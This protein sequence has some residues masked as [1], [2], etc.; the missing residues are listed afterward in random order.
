MG[1]GLGEDLDGETRRRL[2][3]DLEDDGSGKGML[4]GTGA[5]PALGGEG[6]KGALKG[7]EGQKTVDPVAPV[8]KRRGAEVEKPMSRITK[9]DEEGDMKSLDR[10]GWRTLYLVVK[11]ADGRWIFPSARLV[12]REN[13]RQ[14]SRIP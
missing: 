12:G 11:L 1:E 5:A 9:A 8:K 10:V 3:G 13:L 2:V 6:E 14:V 7:G 4:P